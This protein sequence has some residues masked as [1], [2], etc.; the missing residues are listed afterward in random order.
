MYIVLT[1]ISRSRYMIMIL[2]VIL[3]IERGKIKPMGVSAVRASISAA[4]PR[5][6]KPGESSPHR[7][8]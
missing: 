1:Y 3:L 6:A 8:L 7:L 4:G 5:I 2:L